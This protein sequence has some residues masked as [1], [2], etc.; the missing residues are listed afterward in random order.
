M[1]FLKFNWQA[2][3]SLFLNGWW[4]RVYIISPLVDKIED[5]ED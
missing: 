5:F 2:L 4:V 3:Y 1:L